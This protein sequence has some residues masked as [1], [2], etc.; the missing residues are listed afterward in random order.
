MFEWFENRSWLWWGVFLI[1]L[2]VALFLLL[3]TTGYGMS[4]PFIRDMDAEFDSII[5]KLGHHAQ[6][7]NDLITR[8]DTM[9]PTERQQHIY[10]LAKLQGELKGMM[11]YVFGKS[12]PTSKPLPKILPGVP[13]PT[14][15]IVKK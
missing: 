9:S 13:T 12:T 3:W 4:S 11:H 6:I 2:F 15:T 7:N 8:W 1:I 5:M 14:K 10:S